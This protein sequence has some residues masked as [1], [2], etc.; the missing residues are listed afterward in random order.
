MSTPEYMKKAAQNYREKFD[1]VQIR[2]P[3]GMKKEIESKTRKSV[4]A[5]I[6]ELVENEL[7]KY[8]SNKVPF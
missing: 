8:E 6:N 2:L 3:K 7:K 1:L 5:F 4:N